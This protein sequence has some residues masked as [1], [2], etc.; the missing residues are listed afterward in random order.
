[1]NSKLNQIFSVS[2]KR[3]PTNIITGFLGAGKTSTIL[4]LLKNKPNDQ[5]WAILVNEFGEIGMDGA[6]FEGQYPEKEGVFIREV[7]GGCMCCTAGQ[8]MRVALA[9]LLRQAKPDRLLIEP[10]GLGHP[11]EVLKTLHEES[12]KDVIAIEKI[13]TLVDARH[14]SDVRYVEH[15]TF[16]QQIDIADVI[17]ANKN[18]LYT[19]GDKAALKEYFQNHSLR[20]R[21]LYFT[22]HGVI[23]QSLLDK[24]KEIAPDGPLVSLRPAN[25]LRPLAQQSASDYDQLEFNQPLPASGFIKAVNQGEGFFGVGWRF[26][27]KFKFDRNKLF[28]FLSGIDAERLKA[29]FITSKGYF[30]YN[31]TRDALT[32]NS[33]EHLDESRIEII[34]RHINEEWEQELFNCVLKKTSLAESSS[35]TH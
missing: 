13:L 11:K 20:D 2:S 31:F 7:P 8:P 3:V 1:M 29:A 34:T 25:G 28:L 5:R 14:L 30:S 4:H 17:I 21:E 33:F 6:L 32:E 18:D 27:S 10:T 19:Q 15:E 12:F 23:E 22:A 24:P 9:Q 26:S 16:Q 35:I